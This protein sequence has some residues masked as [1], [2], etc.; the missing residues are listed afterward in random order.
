MSR[1]ASSIERKC[2]TD[3]LF[4]EILFNG[5]KFKD[6]CPYYME[7]LMVFWKGGGETK[8]EEV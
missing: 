8:E 6:I 2:M 4:N 3:V 7:H 1:L 5:K